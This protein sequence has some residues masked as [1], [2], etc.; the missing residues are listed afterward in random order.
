M[1]PLNNLPPKE[2]EPNPLRAVNNPLVLYVLSYN[3]GKDTQF[4]A[5]Q[6]HSP[7]K[8]A[9]LRFSGKIVRIDYALLPNRQWNQKQKHKKQPW[10]NVECFA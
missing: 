1:S 2:G 4:C 7:P 8:K 3:H 9:I 6:A 10:G 5:I